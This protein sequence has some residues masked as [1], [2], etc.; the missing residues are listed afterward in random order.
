MAT[1]TLRK[2][3][4]EVGE[5][6]FKVDFEGEF[7]ITEAYSVFLGCLEEVEAEMEKVVGKVLDNMPK[8]VL[9]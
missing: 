2:I 3:I 5:E 4:I 8:G 6:S 9:H 1:D 7:T